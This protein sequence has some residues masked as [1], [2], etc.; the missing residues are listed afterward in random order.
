ML[1]IDS[2]AYPLLERVV[3]LGIVSGPTSG[4]AANIVNI[5]STSPPLIQLGRKGKMDLPQDTSIRD[6]G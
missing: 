3:V 1:G 2:D 5:G 4:L 6:G